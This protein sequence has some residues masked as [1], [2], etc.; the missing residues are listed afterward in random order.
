ME[1]SLI[2]NYENLDQLKKYSSK[3]DLFKNIFQGDFNDV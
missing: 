2:K 3:P 1:K